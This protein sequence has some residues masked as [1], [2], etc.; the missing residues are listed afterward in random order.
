MTTF[1]IYACLISATTVYAALLARFRRLWE[2]DLTWLEVVIGVT[3]CLT[4]P[5]L[6]QRYN[7]PLTSEL[8]ER[9]V[10]MGFLIGG[11][12]IVAWQLGQSVRARLL[13]ER[14]I[15]GKPH[16]ITRHATDRPAPLADEPGAASQA[17]D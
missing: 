6:D 3:L 16:G 12:P 17:D 1:V 8:Y 13:A 5:Y 15:R 2:P 11:L 14:R 10:W 7:G 9:R 4:A